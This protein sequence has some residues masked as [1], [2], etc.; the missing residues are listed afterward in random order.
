M[1]ILKQYLI[2]NCKRTKSPELLPNPLFTSQYNSLGKAFEK[3]YF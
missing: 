3:Q 1:Y 2:Q